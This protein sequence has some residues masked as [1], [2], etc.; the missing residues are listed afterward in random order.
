[1]TSM[2]VGSQ[3]IEAA[4]ITLPLTKLHLPY[5]TP[6]TEVRIRARYACATFAARELEDRY[7][8]T[9]E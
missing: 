9:G 6:G 4:T 1:M 3:R 2:S 8:Q 7:E 5:T